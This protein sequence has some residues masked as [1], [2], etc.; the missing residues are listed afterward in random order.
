M[1]KRPISR[2]RALIDPAP[3][4]GTSTHGADCDKTEKVELSSLEQAA[5]RQIHWQALYRRDS[6]E[7]K[8]C[9]GLYSGGWHWTAL[10]YVSIILRPCL[11]GTTNLASQ[12]W[13]GL[14]GDGM[15]GTFFAG[16][17]SKG[18][19]PVASAA[20]KALKTNFALGCTLGDCIGLPS[21]V[22]AS[23]CVHTYEES[24][25]WPPRG[26]RIAE[27]RDV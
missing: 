9:F 3:V 26:T 5:E 14:W 13:D 1:K 10:W 8:L 25:T 23:C 12:A 2:L 11:W 20:Q 16:T 7:G 21:S 19:S 24:P 17:G 22:P 15:S 6:I 4:P 27:R 18:S